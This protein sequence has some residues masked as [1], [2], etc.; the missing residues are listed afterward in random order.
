MLT[1][2]RTKQAE[3]PLTPLEIKI[4]IMQRGDS[5]AGLARKWGTW[6]EVLSSVINRS[7][8]V[9]QPELRQK[10]ADYLGV[11]VWRVGSEPQRADHVRQSSA[12]A[13]PR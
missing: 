13:S 9:V 4:E 7:P 2:V 10:L 11:E 6:R 1:D 3:I 12:L 5:I 8:G